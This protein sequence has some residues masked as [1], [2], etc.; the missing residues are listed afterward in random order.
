MTV[1]VS[2]TVILTVVLG[3][4]I[5]LIGEAAAQDARAQMAA[6]SAALAAAAETLPGAAGDPELQ[7]RRFAALNGGRLLTCLCNAQDSA[8][9]V[10]VVVGSVVARARAVMDPTLLQPL[11]AFAGTGGLHP[12]LGSAVT[13]L[14]E[15]SHG[16]IYVVSGFRGPREQ[17]RLWASALAEH[18]SVESADD[19]VA[20]PGTSMHERG[21]AVDLGG[22]L[23]LADRLV[24]SMRLP[25]TRP[26]SHEPWHFELLDTG[27]L[28][29][30]SS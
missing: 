8:V 23:A 2:I 21:L 1:L 25:L 13:R 28:P 30:A 4:G 24:R 11:D 29:P 22:D 16:S 12:A 17:A 15:A 7:A 10:T 9:Q 18:G 3:G 27:V 5:A 14:I 26:L 19:W 6:D 20:P